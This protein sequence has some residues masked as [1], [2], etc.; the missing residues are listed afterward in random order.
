MTGQ[1]TRWEIEV[2]MVMTD[3]DGKPRPWTLNDRPHWSKR[4][5]NAARIKS[6]VAWRIKQA[7]IPMLAH[8]TVQLHYAPGDARK[9]DADN[10]VASAKPAV[11]AIVGLVVKDDTPEF[12][13][14]LMPVIH[15][16]SRRT[17]GVRRLWLE[18]TASGPDTPPDPCS[19]VLGSPGGRDDT[20]EHDET[21]S[22]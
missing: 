19:P 5:M 1:A 16:G 17:C 2:P 21:R 10:L 14:H 7:K 8:V 9:R 12:V 6:D 13:T 18:I 20:I 4:R 15:P 11:D 3:R 22:S